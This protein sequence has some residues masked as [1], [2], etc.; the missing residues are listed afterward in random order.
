M[1]EYEPLANLSVK[2]QQLSDTCS[3]TSTRSLSACRNAKVID[4]DS[5]SHKLKKILINHK[6]KISEAISSFKMSKK[7]TKVSLF[8]LLFSNKRRHYIKAELAS[9]KEIFD[10][11]SHE[12]NR[13]S[14]R[15]FKKT[16]KCSNFKALMLKLNLK[17]YFDV[18]TFEVICKDYLKN[19]LIDMKNYQE[20]KI[21]ESV[22]NDYEK[23]G[24]IR[25]QGKILS[26]VFDDAFMRMMNEEVKSLFLDSV[27]ERNTEEVLNKFSGMFKSEIKSKS[28]LSKVK[29]LSTFIFGSKNQQMLRAIMHRF[30]R[31]IKVIKASEYFSRDLLIMVQKSV[32]IENDEFNEKLASLQTLLKINSPDGQIN[33]FL[34]LK[35]L[36]KYFNLFDALVLFEFL[37]ESEAVLLKLLDKYS[38]KTKLPDLNKYTNLGLGYIFFGLFFSKS[39][40]LSVFN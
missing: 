11:D 16:D 24:R 38:S 36:K 13:R 5:L 22:F 7:T 33:K 2:S 31:W 18:E 10:S 28:G 1:K 21:I 37:A 32:N 30:R 34:T 27:L 39:Q 29:V 26:E 9:K 40:A 4:F 17:S 3:N 35:Y 20:S 23:I 19:G 14:S 6:E 12:I 8:S 15:K 25:M